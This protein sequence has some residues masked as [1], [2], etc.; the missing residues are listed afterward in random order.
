MIEKP[1]LRI[2]S[3]FYAKDRLNELDEIPRLENGEVDYW[4]ASKL[5]CEKD[6]GR[7]PTMKE[8]AEIASY[9]YQEKIGKFEDKYDMTPQNEFISLGNYWSSSE[10]SPTHAYLRRFDDDYSGW[11]RN[12]G[13][14]SSDYRSL[15]V[16]D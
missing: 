12:G 13:R 9:I 11:Y 16:G 5:L 7:L 10:S 15:C 6:G 1:N 14:S 2:I 3:N 8:L 4:K